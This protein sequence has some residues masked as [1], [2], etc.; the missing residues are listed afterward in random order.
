MDYVA[1]YK[2]FSWYLKLRLKLIY[3]RQ[4]VLVSGSHLEPMATLLSSL[5]RLRVSWYGTPSLT[6]GRAC[7]LLY[8]CFWALPEQSLLGPSPVELTT[9]FYCLI[10]D[11]PNLECQVPVFISPRN[12]V[13]QIYPRALGY[14]LPSKVKANQSVF[15]YVGMLFNPN[16][17]AGRPS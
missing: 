13:A 7:N 6:R 14:W 5:W 12:R 4:S 2:L 3:D 8:N 1:L 9:I 17:N 15:K 10:W 16:L 11:P